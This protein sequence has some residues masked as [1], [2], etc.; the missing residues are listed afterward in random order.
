MILY[1]FTHPGN[2]MLISRQGLQPG[3]SED[4]LLMTDGAPVVWLTRQESNIATASEVADMAKVGM[5]YKEGAMM[6]GGAARLTVR[7]EPQKRLQRY[8]D[9]PSVKVAALTPAVLNDWYVYF[10]TI[11]PSKID[12]T[13]PAPIILECLDH[14]IATHPDEKSRENFKA[15]RA[16]VAALPP[17]R[18]ACF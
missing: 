15:M 6:F 2:V 9:L 1:H 11:P 14:H 10:G 12:T 13:M 5:D 4:T 16:Q 17:G 3:A 18:T 8:C 7:L